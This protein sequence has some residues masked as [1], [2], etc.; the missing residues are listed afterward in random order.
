[1]FWGF[2]ETEKFIWNQILFIDLRQ[3]LLTEISDDIIKI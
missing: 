2:F 3:N 1:M